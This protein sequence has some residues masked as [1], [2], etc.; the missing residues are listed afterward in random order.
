[1]SMTER[2]KDF[3]FSRQQAYRSVF[4]GPKGDIVTADL[5]RFCRAV[6]STGH[7]DPHMAARLDG[8]REVF[9]RIQQHLQLSQDDLWKLL[10][11]EQ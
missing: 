1:M 3:L 11:G 9:L 6:E 2:V 8:R 5:A 4:D 10:N 7:P